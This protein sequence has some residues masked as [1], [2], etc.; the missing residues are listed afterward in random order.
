MVDPLEAYGTEA[1]DPCRSVKTIDEDVWRTAHQ[2]HR[3]RRIQHKSWKM[4]AVKQVSVGVLLATAIFWPYATQFHLLTRLLISL[5]ALAVAFQAINTGSYGF[6]VLFAATA[7]LYNPF[8]PLF[9]FS[10]V[11]NLI[12]VLASTVPFALSL[13][14]MKT[15][16][17]ERDRMSGTEGI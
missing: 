10:G 7:V 17:A 16:L 9:V 6:A 8:V 15:T 13:T 14:R 11:P 3:R 4:R 5:G 1:A 2:V 12:L